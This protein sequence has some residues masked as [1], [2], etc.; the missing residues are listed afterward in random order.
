M[1]YRIGHDLLVGKS[2]LEKNTIVDIL[3]AGTRFLVVNHKTKQATEITINGEDVFAHYTNGIDQPETQ[4]TEGRFTLE[5]DSTFPQTRKFD[6][7]TKV[8][9]HAE[10]KNALIE[11][12]GYVVRNFWSD[13][14]LVSELGVSVPDRYWKVGYDHLE[15][16]D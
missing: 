12:Q 13:Y 10:H 5:P 9:F 11:I 6:V 4:D 8:K 14:Y 1:F 7:G 15:N 16:V 3:E 2:T